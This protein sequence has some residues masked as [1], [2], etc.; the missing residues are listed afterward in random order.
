MCTKGKVKPTQ[1]RKTD[2]DADQ[3]DKTPQN[4]VLLYSNSSLSTTPNLWT[5]KFAYH[6]INHAYKLE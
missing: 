1:R 4:Q 6:L 3:D 5:C 2:E